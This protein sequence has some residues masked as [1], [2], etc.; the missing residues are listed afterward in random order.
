MDSEKRSVL[1]AHHNLEVTQAE[2][3]RCREAIRGGSIWQLAE[4]RS[5]SSPQLRDAFTWVLEQLEVIPDGPVGVSALDLMV[6]T[7]PVRS[8]GEKLSYD[9]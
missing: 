9:I 7:N 2:L 6:S 8:G 4:R 3:A 1:L 5:H